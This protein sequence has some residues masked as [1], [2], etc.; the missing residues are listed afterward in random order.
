MY[1]YEKLSRRWRA[2]GKKAGRRLN[3]W[4]MVARRKK[5]RIGGETEK[6]VG[7]GEEESARRGGRGQ[8]QGKHSR[9]KEGLGNCRKTEKSEERKRCVRELWQLKWRKQGPN[10]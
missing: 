10:K 1:V 9:A 3:K 7:D 6:E 5:E 2:A 4:D 8:K